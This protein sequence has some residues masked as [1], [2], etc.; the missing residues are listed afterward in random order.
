MFSFQP[1]T[2]LIGCLYGEVYEC[3]L[4]E[5]E[6]SYTD[7]SYDLYRVEPRKM[8]FKSTKS[9][10]R[11]DEYLAEVAKRKE[12]KREKKMEE[13]KLIKKENPGFAIDEERFL[14]DSEDEEVLEPLYFPKIPN[15]VLCLQYTP[16][17][18]V[19]LSMSGYDAGYVYEYSFGKTEPI[20]CTIIPN[21]D[22][23]EIHSFLY[24]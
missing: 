11:R 3:D 6:R 20:S 21:G 9:Q 2:L 19:W 5:Q 22:D 14:K 4:P 7:I 10:I 8:K 13:L 17:E 24:W 15:R 12:K 16:D 18:T 1:T 23:I